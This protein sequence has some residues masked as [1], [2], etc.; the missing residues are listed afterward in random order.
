MILLSYQRTK[1]FFLLFM[2]WIADIDDELVQVQ[3]NVWQKEDLQAEKE[4][5]AWYDEVFSA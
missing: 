2:K 3:W 1:I 4:V 5:P